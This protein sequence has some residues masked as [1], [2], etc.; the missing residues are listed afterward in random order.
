MPGGR[1]GKEDCSDEKAITVDVVIDNSTRAEGIS[2]VRADRYIRPLL[3]RGV[4]KHDLKL[5][6]HEPS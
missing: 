6:I 4:N 2:G 5:R 3:P 1:S